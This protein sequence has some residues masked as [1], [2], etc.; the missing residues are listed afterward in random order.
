[1]LKNN[2]QIC[3]RMDGIRYVSCKSAKDRTAMSVTLEEVTVLKKEHDLSAELFN[4][5]L[6]ALRR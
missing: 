3:K 6:D 4:H 2:F 5:A 1:M